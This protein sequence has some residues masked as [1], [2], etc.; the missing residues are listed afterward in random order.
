MAINILS[1]NE[2]VSDPKVRAG[3]PV[4]AGT[5]IRV[6][7]IVAHHLYGD[8]LSPEQIATDF[9]LNLGQ[10]HA[11]LAYYY[12]HQQEVDAQLQQDA[13]EAKRLKAQLGQQGRLIE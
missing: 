7:D 1:I 6:M 11:A 4:I 5:G 3:K 10:V 9:R 2:I 13:E 8:Q 12:L